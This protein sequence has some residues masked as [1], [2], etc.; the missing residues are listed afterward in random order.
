MLKSVQARCSTTGNPPLSLL[1][2]TIKVKRI[3]WS[4]LPYEIDESLNTPSMVCY[5]TSIPTQLLQQKYT[6][7]GPKQSPQPL[8]S[9]SRLSVIAQYIRDVPT[10][11]IPF[12]W[13]TQWNGQKTNDSLRVLI[14]GAVDFCLF[15][16]WHGG[17]A[18]SHP[19]LV[20]GRCFVTAAHISSRH[21]RYPVVSGRDAQG[22]NME[23][24]A[25]VSEGVN[26]RQRKIHL[27]SKKVPKS[28][29]GSHR[30]LLPRR[31]EF[32]HQLFPKS[33]QVGFVPQ[34]SDN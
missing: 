22:H 21:S 31:P 9:C 15:L 6:A 8:Q 17:P 2:L 29:L 32:A 34:A 20:R 3:I 33:N 14:V 4:D 28:V 13:E 12:P 30:Q 10:T 23:L 27:L 16:R 24:S 18:N 1:H 5:C 7:Q 11:Q 19:H 25:S 26:R